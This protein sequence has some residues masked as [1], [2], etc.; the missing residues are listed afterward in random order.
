MFDSTNGFGNNKRGPSRR[1]Y[2]IVVGERGVA[3]AAGVHVGAAHGA[4][5][6]ARRLEVQRRHAGR[7]GA[8]R[9]YRR[10]DVAGQLRPVRAAPAPAPARPARVTLCTCE[11]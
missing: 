7:H 11:C 10:P 3:V 8:G 5:V 6:V 4:V 2:L 1:S 9:R